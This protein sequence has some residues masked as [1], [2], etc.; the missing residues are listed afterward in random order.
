MMRAWS[1]RETFGSA[2]RSVWV[3]DVDVSGARRRW[4]AV[5]RASTSFETVVV[6]VSVPLRFVVGVSHFVDERDRIWFVNEV[7]LST[8]GVGTR[9]E[10]SLSRYRVGG[11]TGLRYSG[12]EGVPVRTADRMDSRGC[13][14][15]SGSGC[16]GATGLLHVLQSA[17][18]RA[19]LRAVSD[20]TCCW[21]QWLP[22][23]SERGSGIA[24]FNV[25]D[26]DGTVWIVKL[27]VGGSVFL[28][29]DGDPYASD[30]I[31]GYT[32][33]ELAGKTLSQDADVA[34]G[35]FFVITGSS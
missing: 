1:Y 19:V 28:F 8:V 24:P 25:A 33:P 3:A 30:A 9:T 15:R 21:R 10:V 17:Q 2:L 4:R 34:V 11:R 16:P 32:Q 31:S 12:R 35:D 5:R 13:R 7:A 6:A 29:E 22:C 18:R 26:A 14:G 20:D 27:N 23:G